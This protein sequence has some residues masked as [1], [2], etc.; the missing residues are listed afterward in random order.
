MAN[1]Y[2]C[3]IC[4]KP[5]TVH[6]TKIID[7]KKVKIHLCSECA[8]KASL[9]AINIPA[10]I[11]PKIQELE[12]QMIMGVS[13]A[14]K[15]GICP[16]CA[17]S[18]AEVEKGARFGCPD[19]Y[20]AFAEK[21]PEFLSQIQGGVMH[22]G[23]TPKHHT[24]STLLNPIELLG[25]AIENV[26]KLF[27]D[28]KSANQVN[29]EDNHAAIESTTANALVENLQ[30]QENNVQARDDETIEVLRVKLDEAIRE[31]RY[32]DAAKLRDKINSF[33]R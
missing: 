2:K 5:A 21:M 32:E 17:T 22:V 15:A 12:E 1:E 25:K 3:D 7:S 29:P 8:E 19:C 16:T 10:Q 28:G 23:K 33:L 30:M 4:G 31:E 26:G 20:D 24:E 27:G 11:L 14:S 13:K 6:I 18:F 9:D